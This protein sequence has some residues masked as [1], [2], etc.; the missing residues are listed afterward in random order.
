MPRATNGKTASDFQVPT[1]TTVSLEDVEVPEYQR[2]RIDKWAKDIADN[3]NPL[4]FR[5][6]LLARRTDGKLD[7]IDGQHTIEAVKLRGHTTVPA[8]VRDGLEFAVEAG[9][10][11]DMNTRRRGLRP[12][13]VWRAEKFAGKQWAVDLNTVAEKNGLKVAHERSPMALAC[14]SEARRILRKDNGAELLDGALFVLTRAWDDVK[15]EAN[16]ARVERGLVTGMADLIERVSPKG[17]FD[18]DGWVKKL[19]EATFTVEGIKIKV[20]PS[21]FTSYVSQMISKG[22]ITLTS[23]QTGSGQN[24]IFGKA[25]ALLILGDRRASTYYK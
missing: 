11:A 18:A 5:P 1:V 4:L 6:P 13:E 9:A 19:K 15:D 17:L 10:F 21:N 8:M 7:I 24:L 22:K 23:V 12:F 14:I 20:T 2:G 3:W 16:Q 25:L